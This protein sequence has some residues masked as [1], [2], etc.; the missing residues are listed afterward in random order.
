M[1]KLIWAAVFSLLL[2]APGHAGAE[3][4]FD[5][6]AGAAFTDSNDVKISAAG[7]STTSES[8]F[9]TSFS[10]GGRFGYWFGFFGLN[11][12]VDYFRPN[13]DPDRA[14]VA[15]ITAKTEVD[16]LGV[17]VNA[18]L[19]ARLL[20]T[21]AVPDGA[22]QPYIFAGPT[23]FITKFDFDVTGAGGSD[24]SVDANLGFTAG[25]GVT[26]MFTKNF[27]VFGEYRFTYN[28]PSL[29]ITGVKIEPKLNSHHLLG[30]VTLRF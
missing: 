17:G 1:R 29:E 18:M 28:R 10:V 24:V 26:Y 7:L 12:D 9:K 15:G 11:L 16:V 13:L 27:G 19:R 20:N 5:L 6:F 21:T 3:G 22:L 4:F 8:D 2:V 30:G 14:T 25:T 23:V